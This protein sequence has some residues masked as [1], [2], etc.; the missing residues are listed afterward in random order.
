MPRKFRITLD[1]TI[2]A[3]TKDEREEMGVLAEDC[4]GAVKEFDSNDLATTIAAFVLG[5]QDEFLAGTDAMIKI[6]SIVARP[7]EES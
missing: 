6:K 4:R 5:D 1:V 3:F 7:V 2:R